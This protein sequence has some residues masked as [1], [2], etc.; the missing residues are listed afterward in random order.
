MNQTFATLI[1]CAPKLDCT[2]LT[3]V[4]NQLS[5]TLDQKFV[6]ECHVNYDL[7]NPVVAA[8]V[9]YKTIE[10]GQVIYRLVT[11]AKERNIAYT[12]N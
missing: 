6:K 1:H 8:N 3:A 11:L 5:G 9:D 7:L 10:Q 12:P 2:E 4:V